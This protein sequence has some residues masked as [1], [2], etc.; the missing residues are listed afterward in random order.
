MNMILRD[1]DFFDCRMEEKLDV[2]ALKPTLQLFAIEPTQRDHRDFH[3]ESPA[4]PKKRVNKNLAD[5]AEA[6]TVRCLIQGAGQNQSPKTVHGPGGL[7]AAN[8]P[9]LEGRIRF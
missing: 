2:V 3:F 8:E 5:I 6:D 4:A 7:T 1:V 9:I